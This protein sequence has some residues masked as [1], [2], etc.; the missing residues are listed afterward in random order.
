VIVF[1]DGKEIARH[2][3]VTSKERLLALLAS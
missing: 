3:G 1:K 2:V